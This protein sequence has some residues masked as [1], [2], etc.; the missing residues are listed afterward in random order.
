MY[1][2][3]VTDNS[4]SVGRLSRRLYHIHVQLNSS[5][6]GAESARE[7]LATVRVSETERE[8]G[9]LSRARRERELISIVLALRA[10]AQFRKRDCDC[11]VT[12]VTVRFR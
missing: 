7:A 12:W 11:I 6:T 5:V 10:R 4:L 9:G 8:R 3:I 1:I 2:Y